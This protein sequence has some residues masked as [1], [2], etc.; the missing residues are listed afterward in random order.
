ML[1]YKINSK[2]IKTGYSY[3]NTMT[4]IYMHRLLL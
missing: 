1:A 4:L 3:L 2:N